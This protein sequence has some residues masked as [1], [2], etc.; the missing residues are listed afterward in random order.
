MGQ[1]RTSG[2]VGRATR[3][4]LQWVSATGNGAD[5]GEVGEASSDIPGTATRGQLEGHDICWRGN[6]AGHQLSIRLLEAAEI[7]SQDF[8]AFFASR[9]NNTDR[10]CAAWSSEL[11][12]HDCGNSDL[13]LVDPEI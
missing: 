3:V 4:T 12:D 8:S 13:P 2:L 5:S 9:F 11:E 6:R 7:T 1:L 10:P